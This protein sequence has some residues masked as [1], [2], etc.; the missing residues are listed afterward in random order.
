MDGVGEKGEIRGKAGK[1]KEN[2]VFK[3]RNKERNR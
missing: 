2:E 3:E 1:R